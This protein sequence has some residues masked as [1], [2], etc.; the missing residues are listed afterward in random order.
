MNAALQA[1]HRSGQLRGLLLFL[2][3]IGGG[4]VMALWIVSGSAQM[5]TMGGIAIIMVIIVGS[6][7]RNWRVGFFLFIPWVL[8]EDLARKY[9]GN[10][11]ALFFGKDVLA[12][13]IY[14]SL[15]IAI[16]RR[17]VTW[18]RPPFLIPLALFAALAVIQVFN[19]W[20]PSVIYGLLGL[21]LYFFYVPLIFVGYTLV[22]TGRE[23]EH[24]LVY[25]VV[26]GILIAALGIV[27]SVIGFSF[28][29]PATLAPELQHLGQLTRYSP[30]THLAVVA[31]T[32]VFVSTGRFDAFVVLTMILALSA[33]AYLLLKRRNHAV[34]GFLGIGI[35]FV[36]AMQSGSR[37]CIIYTVMCALV[38][39][40]GFLWGAPWRWGRGQRLV[41]AIR[42]TCLVGAAGLFLMIEVFPASIGASWAF[43]SETLSPTS[44]ASELRYRSWDYPIAG[45]EQAFQHERWL[46]G[47]GTGTASLG[48]EYVARLLDQPQINN[49]VENGWGELILEMGILGPVLWLIWSGSVLYYAW[50]IVRHLRGTIYFPVAFS[51]FWYAF[52]LLIPFTYGGLSSYQNYVMNAYFWLLMGVLYRLPHLARQEVV[53][54]SQVTAPTLHGFAAYPG[55]R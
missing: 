10:G 43:Y 50:K 40:A 2:G 17:N 33:Q 7:L 1:L 25:N 36:A 45:L 34:Y 22:R 19:T 28:L 3:L 8:F 51:I 15:S 44:S 55:G 24:F 26:L 31:P 21:K 14:L 20:T 53:G 30:I 37:G 4:W 23:L 48:T 18:F 39:S 9:L 35:A 29:S 41:T 6:T 5:L 54:A 16:R 12:F 11:T 49:W 52:L 42:R 47:Y 46:Y 32:S 27:Q 13:V 38:L